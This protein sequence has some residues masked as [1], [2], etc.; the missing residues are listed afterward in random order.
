ME[1]DTPHPLVERWTRFRAWPVGTALFN[2]V[3]RWTVPY[4]GSIRPRVRRLDV[5]RAEIEIRDRR[6]VRNHLRSIHAAALAHLGEM[7][8][9]LALMTRQPDHG[10]W[11]V[12]DM[13]AE[14]HRKA[15][16]TIVAEAR[17]EPV[18]WGEN[19]DI[20]GCATLRNRA[21]EAVATVT[22]SWKI[23]PRKT[24]RATERATSS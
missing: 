8:A 4:A 17:V 11:I 10:R 9:N 20:E 21:G 24:P 22:L 19:R 1:P 2:Q 18:D 15:R 5:G 14:Y 6:S 13:R 23:G 16:G 3:I 7:T 12:A